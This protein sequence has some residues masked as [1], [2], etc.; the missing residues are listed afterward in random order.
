[1]NVVPIEQV[2]LEYLAR[3][4]QQCLRPLAALTVRCD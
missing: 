3:G 2:S 4:R 1:V